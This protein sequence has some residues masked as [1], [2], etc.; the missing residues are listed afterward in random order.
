MNDSAGPPHLPMSL[1]IYSLATT[2]L[3]TTSSVPASVIVSSSVGPA[4]QPPASRELNQ[5][6]NLPPV[7][8]KVPQFSTGPSQQALACQVDFTCLQIRKVALLW[9]V[10]LPY[11]LLSNMSAR[12]NFPFT[13][14]LCPA[15]SQC[16]TQREREKGEG[17]NE[18]A[19]NISISSRF[20][21]SHT[22]KQRLGCW[23]LR[24]FFYC[25]RSLPL[26][27]IV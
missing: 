15:H 8:S 13:Y 23:W 7:D 10:L 6:H 17:E 19:G 2:A 26:V 21:F 14:L 9:P 4:L 22:S 1:P 12:L 25:N 18:K 3:S 24:D 27:E 20:V 16:S 11:F 5:S